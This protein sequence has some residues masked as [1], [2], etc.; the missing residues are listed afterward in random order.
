MARV[1]LQ[2][3]CDEAR[4]RINARA[5]DDAIAICRHILQRYPKHIRAFQIL[6]EACLEKGDLQEAIDIFSRLLNH[7]D[8]EN[9]VAYAGLGV[10]NEE[11]GRIAEATWYMERAFELASS[12]EDIRNALRRLYGKRDGTEPTRIKLNKMAL[13]RLYARGGQYR[14]AIEEFRQLLESDDNAGRTDIKLSLAETLFRDGRR[15]QAAELLREIL[16]GSPDCLKGIL[17]LGMIYMEKG[18][19]EEGRAILERAR[20]LDPE[21]RMA[22]TL[23]GDSSPLPAQ[24]VKL[25]RAKEGAEMEPP[26]AEAET[27]PTTLEEELL[28]MGEAEEAPSE[29][30]VE[31]ELAPA[32]EPAVEV[33]ASEESVSQPPPHEEAEAQTEA[34]VEAIS[35]EPVTA[36]TNE[37]AP[38]ETTLASAAAVTSAPL[39]EVEQ[40][41]LLLE[42]APKDDTVRLALAR[43]YR[44]QE[45]MKLALECYSALVRAKSDILAQAVS[46][47]ESIVASRPDNLEAH[48]LLADL[49]SQSGQLQRAVDRY[50]W[51]LQQLEA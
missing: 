4:A 11:Q 18:R 35:T 45:Q 28:A 42:Q 26:S 2:E 43:A 36:P 6:G 15:E 39:S 14:Q 34:P 12:N 33:S 19:V 23:F 21:N 38:D 1:T 41:R 20:S 5:Y 17:L 30:A 10:A 32:S 46:D 29:E 13:A 7:A 51:I 48:E 16:Q 50:R 9:F 44:N 24:A 25:P 49:Y 27:P 3:Y 31:P 8:P 40:Y 37:L 22:A 47:V